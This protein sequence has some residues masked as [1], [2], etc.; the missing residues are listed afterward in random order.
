MK[1]P[2]TNPALE[3]ATDVP[4]GT[5]YVLN[6]VEYTIDRGPTINDLAEVEKHLMKLGYVSGNIPMSLMSAALF[7][8]L[9]GS[10]F[11][12]ILSLPM[13]YMEVMA[14]ALNSFPQTN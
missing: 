8:R 2:T 6:G 9:S 7:A 13:G 1:T 14:N 3:T 10:N 5:V 4:K 12:T 11:D